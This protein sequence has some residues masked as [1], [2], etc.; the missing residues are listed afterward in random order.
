M[1]YKSTLNLPQTDFSMK[2]NLSAREPETLARWE[3]MGLYGKIRRAFQGRELF[4]LHDGPPYANGHIHIGHALNKILKDVIVRYKTLRGYDA[5]YIPGWDCHGLP[6]EHQLF[7]DLKKNKDQIDRVAFR[8][9]AYDY[10]MKYVAIQRDEFKRLGI[11]GDWEH[12]YL[13]LDRKY[14]EAILKSFGRLVEEGYIYRG[15]K[16]VHWCFRCETALAE[17]EVEYENH[18]SD[19]IYVKFE[20]KNEEHAQ[21]LGISFEGKKPPTICIWTT[22]PWTLIANVAVAVHPDME[23][24]LVDFK[25]GEHMI[26]ARDLFETSL[27]E[28][29]ES[30]GEPRVVKRFLGKELE[31]LVYRHPFGLREGRVVLADYVSREDGTG[32]VHTAPGHGQEDFMTGQK[33]HL[34][35]VMPV[36][37]RGRFLP[38][39]ADFSGQRVFDA[40]AGIIQKLSDLGY[41]KLASKITHTYPHCWRCKQP[42]I[43]RATQQWFL[44]IDHKGLRQDLLGVIRDQVAW[45]PASGRERISAM[46]ENRPD[47]CLSRQRYWGVPIPAV[48]CRVCRNHILDARLIEKLAARVAAE[49]TDIW[50]KSDVAEF[51]PKDLRCACGSSAFDK[52]T[53]ILDVWF[54][55][56]VSHQAVLKNAPGLK[57]PA[58]LYLEGSD[59][60]RGWFQASLIP[61]Q[62]IDRQPP[63]KTVLT[64]GFVV[65]AQGRKMSKSLGNVISP[66]EIIKDFGADILRLW[67]LS[68]DYNE[69][70]RI[71]KEIL[72]FTADAYRKIRNTARFILGNLNDF[73]PDA[74]RLGRQELCDIDRWA[75]SRL[76]QLVDGVTRAYDSYLFYHVFQKLFAFCNEEMSSVY[77]DILKDRLYTAGRR[78]KERRSAQTVIYDILDALT[79]M[80]AP[81]LPFT[82]EEIYR[83][84]RH[85][86]GEVAESVHLSSWP[87]FDGAETENGTNK[88]IDKILEIRPAVLK[89]LEEERTKGKIGSSLEAKVILTFKDKQAS[90]VFFRFAQQLRYF[91]IVS[92]VELK[93]DASLGAPF[94][95]SVVHAEG[96]KC[97]R[98]WNYTQDTDVD[99][100]YPGICG[101]CVQAIRG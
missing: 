96:K 70:V 4:I 80:L 28:K 55:S 89:S 82:S 26:V 50:F 8:M 3:E 53:D 39:V 42:V 97:S 17:A 7:K 58:D 98:C 34:D 15:L 64:H 25:I 79:R 27:R 54:D 40:N 84:M 1:D 9:M 52:S 94:A 91:F 46:V 19:S 75:L 37:E 43:F 60:H 51:L 32:C 22:T 12:P 35:V 78:S 73:D 74:D 18:E 11:I 41:L 87:A 101:R 92:C 67:V 85:R 38:D 31:G 65:D 66:Q 83:S 93:T 56:G 36:D 71:S 76:S 77:L 62:A 86:K 45:V 6:V 47:W 72:N 29:F 100:A 49:G 14:E 23:Y 99:A 10:A 33:Y 13:T 63:F 44:K 30:D 16:P 88:D 68:S 57:L 21:N 24:V 48:V 95:I 69:D 90:E 5:P 59:Q 61:S 2:A 81:V 20:L